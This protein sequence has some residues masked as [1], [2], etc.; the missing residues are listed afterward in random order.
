MDSLGALTALYTEVQDR[1]KALK[2]LPDVPTPIHVTKHIGNTVYVD[3]PIVVGSNDFSYSIMKIVTADASYA[4]MRYIVSRIINVSGG[5]IITLFNTPNQDSLIEVGTTVEFSPGPLAQ[6]KVYLMTPPS[7][8]GA[9]MDDDI[10][11]YVVIG[12]TGQTIDTNHMTNTSNR[13]TDLGNNQKRHHGLSVAC[14]VP[15]SDV[16]ATT[17]L[18][19]YDLAIKDIL[20]QEQLLAVIHNFRQND[21]LGRTGSGEIHS[22]PMLLEREAPHSLTKGW[23]ITFVVETRK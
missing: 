1:K 16:S 11:A 4:P 20:L 12:Y 18:E 19:A 10:A 23:L 17:D 6:S 5:A 2:A 8:E 14:E 21:K 15:Y 13:P 22:Q 9:R 3:A 7:M